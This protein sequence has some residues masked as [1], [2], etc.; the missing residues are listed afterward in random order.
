MELGE[1]KKILDRY[2]G[3][4]IIIENGE[5]AMMVMRWDDHQKDHENAR[6][7]RERAERTNRAEFLL[8]ENV[9]IG[10]MKPPVDPPQQKELRVYPSTSLGVNP[11]GLEGLTIDDL[12]L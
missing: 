6:V 7:S 12:P 2:G 3:T 10:A 9:H 5:P 4:C 1:I 11:E 8:P